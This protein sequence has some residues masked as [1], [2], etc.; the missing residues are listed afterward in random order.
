MRFELNS[1]VNL[2]FFELYDGRIE[3][4]EIGR[5]LAQGGLGSFKV[6]KSFDMVFE[7]A[8]LILS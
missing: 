7:I 3:F 2:S 1:V 5:D 6:T 8:E 4:G